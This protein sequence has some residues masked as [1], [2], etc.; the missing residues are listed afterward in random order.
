MWEENQNEFER[1]IQVAVI[2]R[3]H[4]YVHHQQHGGYDVSIHSLRN[5]DDMTELYY[6]ILAD[7]EDHVRPSKSEWGGFIAFA[8]TVHATVIDR[9]ERGELLT[10]AMVPYS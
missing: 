6:A 3:R 5:V 4:E 9:E 1:P 8:H 2:C 7:F 10:E